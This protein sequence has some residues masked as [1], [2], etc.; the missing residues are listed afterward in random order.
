M[1][2]TKTMWAALAMLT[3]ALVGCSS[4][5]KTANRVI[6]AEVSLIRFQCDCFFAENG[7]ASPEECFARNTVTREERD[8][9]VAAYSP[10]IETNIDHVDCLADT[11]EGFAGC[12]RRAGCGITE[13]QID[14]C[15]VQNDP[16]VRCGS[17]EFCHGLSGD[18]LVTCLM[19]GER[20]DRE[21][22][23]CIGDDE[24]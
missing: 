15:E 21:F 24:L 5:S 9:A 1:T 14:A 10:V 12:V 19:E 2:R 17:D 16:V 8:C 23:M 4:G 7:F 20:A 3:M 13:A 22:E 6:D 18:D 11:S